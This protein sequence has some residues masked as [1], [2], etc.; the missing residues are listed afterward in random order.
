[1]EKDEQ[2]VRK[3]I[4]R[5]RKK[6]KN[7]LNNECRIFN[8]SSKCKCRMNT[9]IESIDLPKEYQRI[10]TVAQRISIFRQAEEVLP[11]RIYWE[12]YFHKYVHN[13][14]IVVTNLS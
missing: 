8:P 3:I 13:Q 6:L 14:E 9:L 11:A 1:M 10:R 12:K 4:S 2:D 7:F 5:S